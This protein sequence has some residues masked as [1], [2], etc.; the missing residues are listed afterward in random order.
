MKDSY[1]LFLKKVKNVNNTRKHK[2]KK[3][4][5]TYD[6]FKYYR[7]IRPKYKKYVLKDVEYFNI[8]RT[9]NNKIRD[10][11]S[12]GKEVKLP[13]YMGILTICK[14]DRG[15]SIDSKGKVHNNYPVDWQKT[16]K[17][18]YDDPEA[19]NN[20]ILVKNP[21]KELYN[22]IYRKSKAKFKNQLYYSFAFNRA[23][24]IKLKQ[25]I[26]EGLVEAFKIQYKQ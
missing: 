10:C 24:K 16:L 15:V 13:C 6:A 11:L 4:Y 8:I 12:L 17:L 18:W 7:K 19:Y 1:D 5:G 9:I 21:V 23:L 26:N 20:K 14:E 25:N 22:L 3:S 2:V